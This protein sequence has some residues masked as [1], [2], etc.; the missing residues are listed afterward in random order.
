MYAISITIVTIG[1]SDQE[2]NSVSTNGIAASTPPL[3]TNKTSSA[4]AA[5]HDTRKR[6][7]AVCDIERQRAPESADPARRQKRRLRRPE[8][9]SSLH[10]QP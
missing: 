8:V 4:I 9:I 5:K 6:N 3:T 2:H 1:T 7:E 10:R